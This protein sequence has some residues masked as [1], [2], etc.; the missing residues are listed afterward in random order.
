MATKYKFKK[1][2]PM[3]HHFPGGIGRV[4]L[5]EVDDAFLEKHRDI[6]GHVIDGEIKAPTEVKESQPA[7]DAK[8][9]KSK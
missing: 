4:D 2:A 7:S 9:A 6:I 8:D 1:D 5:N 3:V